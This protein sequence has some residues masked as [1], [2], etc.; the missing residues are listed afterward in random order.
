MLKEA[1]V[2]VSLSLD[3]ML[4]EY[5]THLVRVGAVKRNQALRVARGFVGWSGKGGETL[6]PEL[7]R[8]SVTGY[9]DL[10][11]RYG[12]TSQTRRYMMGVIRAMCSVNRVPWPLVHGEGVRD[13]KDT[14]APG[15]DPRAVVA[16]IQAA[17]DGRLP[18]CAASL[19]ALSTV[20]GLRRTE[21]CSLR[22][23]HLTVDEN[24]NSYLAFYTAKAQNPRMHLVP[25]CILIYLA[26]WSFREPVGLF[27][28]WQ[29]YREIEI[30]AGLKH[31]PEVGWHAIR[32][33]L[34]TLLLE[35][36]PEVQ[37]EAF[38]GWSSSLTRMPKRYHRTSFV[39]YDDE[40]KPYSPKW[41]RD[42]DEAVFKVHPFLKSWE[43]T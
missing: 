2:L 41:R 16:M 28:S 35:R 12:Y 21:L 6:T 34:D 4:V 8:E 31:A 38:L 39:G 17:R 14:Y 40:E 26:N 3:R 36:L 25:P 29:V 18:S 42:I 24:G 30:R 7:L 9:L 1:S 32:R 27:R 33:T 43:E 5:D 13:L 11:E 23:E 15:L 37:V 10:L 22:P 20:Y 19:L